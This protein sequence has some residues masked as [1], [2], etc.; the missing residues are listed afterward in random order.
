VLLFRFLPDAR[1]SW[2]VAF[3]GAF[4]TSLLFNLGKF[5]LRWLLIRSNLG[6]VYGASGSVILLLLFVFYSSLILYYGAAFTKVWATKKG[7]PIKPLHG[8]VHYQLSPID[9]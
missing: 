4:V 6:T 7:Q 3:V 8:A 9:E 5:I 1:P 2:N